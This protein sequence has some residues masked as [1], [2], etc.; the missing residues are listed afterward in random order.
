MIAAVLVDDSNPTRS[1][2][3]D[4][5]SGFQSARGKHAAST[6]VCCCLFLRC[7]GPTRKLKK[8]ASVVPEQ[9]LEGSAASVD[10]M[11]EEKSAKIPRM[12]KQVTI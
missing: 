9:E 5:A 1:A 11:A 6:R 2:A 10:V 12:D 4:C 8:G 3:A 7:F